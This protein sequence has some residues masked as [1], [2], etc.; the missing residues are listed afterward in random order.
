MRILVA[1][2]NLVNQRVASLIL[3][4]FG[5]RPDI[6]GNGSEALAAVQRQSYD[7]VLMDVQMPEMDG[8]EA[9]RRI[10]QEFPTGQ[11]PEIIAMTA[12]AR[13]EDLQECLAAGMDGM[14]TKPMS[15]DKLRLLLE[16]TGRLK[17]PGQERS[18]V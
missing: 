18:I 8:L 2:D 1:E 17:M 5:Y 6:V 16:K 9:T 10:C 7:L 11:R 4:R 15:I 3:G 12:H 14:L 13:P